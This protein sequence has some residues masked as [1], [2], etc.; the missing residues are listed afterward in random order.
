MEEADEPYEHERDGLQA[1]NSQLFNCPEEER[2][3]NTLLK[4]MLRSMRNH[5]HEEID[6]LSTHNLEL[7]YSYVMLEKVL[8]AI[9][10]KKFQLMKKLVVMRNIF[11]NYNPDVI[12]GNGNGLDT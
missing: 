10:D 11:Y 8:K 7:D 3:K 2:K 1:E 6:L 5:F 4:E 9:T 12:S